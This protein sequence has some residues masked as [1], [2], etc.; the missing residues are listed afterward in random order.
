MFR[1]SVHSSYAAT[2]SRLHGYQ[3]CP[4]GV[5]NPMAYIICQYYWSLSNVAVYI[6]IRGIRS[7]IGVVHLRI[8]TGLYFNSIEINC[9][10]RV[11]H[12]LF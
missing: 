11:C 3:K 10:A 1:D 6:S 7:R 2:C 4:Y 5:A 9:L 8:A 12:S